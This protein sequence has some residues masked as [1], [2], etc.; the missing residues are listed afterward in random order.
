MSAVT[1]R[2]QLHYCVLI[3]QDQW[4]DRCTISTMRLSDMHWCR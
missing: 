3:R 2:V 4:K 1:E